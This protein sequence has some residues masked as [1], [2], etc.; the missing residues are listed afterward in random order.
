M[1]LKSVGHYNE[2]RHGIG[3]DLSIHEFLQEECPERAEQI[4][5][6]LDNGVLLIVSPGSSEDVIT[7]G[8]SIPGGNSEFT[9]GTWIWPGDLSY[10]VRNYLLK[11]P[12]DFLN[13][14]VDNNWVIPI[15]DNDIDK[16]TL[17]IDG[18]KL[19]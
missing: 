17:V 10:Y 19:Y 5:S 14:I 7:S 4:C 11:L 6:Y 18:V 12:D 8:N 2:T 13:H 15:S 16:E 1:N 9:D 3:L